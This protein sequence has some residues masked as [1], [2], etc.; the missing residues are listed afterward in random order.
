M[1]VK[2]KIVRG[3]GGGVNLWRV[4]VGGLFVVILNF[5]F[6][7]KKIFLKFYRIIEVFYIVKVFVVKMFIL[8]ILR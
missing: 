4:K 2:Y 8:L 1:F 3:R 5:I 6:L 7:N